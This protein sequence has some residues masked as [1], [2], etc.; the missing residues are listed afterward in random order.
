MNNRTFIIHI[1][2]NKYKQI[3]T[4]YIFKYRHF[5]NLFLIILKENK[6]DFNLLSNYRVMRAVL[7]ETEGGNEKNNVLKIKEKY[8]NNDKLNELINLSKNLKIHNISDLIKKV[9]SNYKTFFTNIK[10]NVKTNTPKAK[11]LSLVSNYSILLDK[12]AFTLKKKDKIGIN[13]SDKMFYIDFNHDYLPNNI[14]SIKVVYSNKDIYLHINYLK[15]D[16]LNYNLNLKEAGIDVGVN[17]LLSIFVNDE[18]TKSIIVDGS[19]YKFYNSS[20]NRQ[21][22]KLNKFISDSAIEFK[23]NKIGTKYATKWTSHGNYLRK[24]KTF[25]YEKRNR[26]FYDQFHKVSKRV[27]EFLKV[28][29]VNN[30][31]ISYNL[32]ELKNNGDCKLKNKQNFIQI[33]F[34]KLLNNIQYKCNEIGIQVDT[35]NESYTS[36]CSCISDDVNNPLDK[37]LN[38]VRSKRGLFKDKLINKVMNADLNG[39][40]NHIRKYNKN[41]FSWLTNYLFKLCNPI[42]IKCDYDFVK[43]L[44]NSVFEQGITEFEVIHTSHHVQNYKFKLT[45]I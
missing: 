12:I 16:K 8:K 1:K 10:N 41:N 27:V 26:Y 7:A 43:Y 31:I 14:K 15:K 23:T 36:K 39:A 21:I 17:N 40:A 37:E 9:K 5:E 30:L 13:L 4:N 35:I 45:K 32:A 42:K 44:K 33:P 28:N 20:F 2:D 29:N 18:T 25:L 11:K 19:P 34:I 6:D 38:G 22:S 3:F 24:Y